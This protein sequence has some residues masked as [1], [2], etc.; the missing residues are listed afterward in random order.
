MFRAPAVES[1]NSGLHRPD[2]PRAGDEMPPT[3]RLDAHPDQASVKAELAS[4][5]GDHVIA[6]QFG[7]SHNFHST[8]AATSTVATRQ[9]RP[10]QPV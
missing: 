2:L 6:R 4:G 10:H 3:F 5:A 9:P 8:F 7:V 1:G